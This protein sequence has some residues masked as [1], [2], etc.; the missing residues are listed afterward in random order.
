MN[1]K[2]E[3]LITSESVLLN[4]QNTFTAFFPFLKIDFLRPSSL[5]A[6]SRSNTVDPNTSLKN[7]NN[8]S[9]PQKIN[10]DNSRTVS[11]VCND[12]ETALG[13]MVKVSRKSGNV[14]NVISVTDGWTLKNQNAAGEYISS[15]MTV[16]PKKD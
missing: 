12:F 9:T 4:I 10:I 11:E 16:A 13:F 6:P 5:S 1:N 3:I 8:I 15:V 7:L 14:W 2:N